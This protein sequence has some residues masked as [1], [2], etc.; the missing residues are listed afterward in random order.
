MSTVAINVQYSQSINWTASFPPA[1]RIIVGYNSNPLYSRYAML[2]QDSLQM[3]YY[4]ASV[5]I[6]IT[7][8]FQAAF[9]AYPALTYPPSITT[10]PTSSQAFTAPGTASFVV[11]AQSEVPMTYQWYVESGSN[12]SFVLPVGTNYQGTSSATLT[13]SYSTNATSSFNYYCAL[14]NSSGLTNT[15]TVNL[16]IS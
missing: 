16:T 13:V 2:T 3:V 10:K 15:S 4:T 1:Q 7:S 12:A 8:L 14:N 5:S 9:T 6:P 11:V